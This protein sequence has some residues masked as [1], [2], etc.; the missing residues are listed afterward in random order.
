M[1]TVI[2]L[3]KAIKTLSTPKLL[4]NDQFCILTSASVTLPLISPGQDCEFFFQLFGLQ[5]RCIVSITNYS[6]AS[7]I[8]SYSYAS[9]AAHDNEIFQAKATNLFIFGSLD[10]ARIDRISCPAPDDTNSFRAFT[11]HVVTPG[12]EMWNRVDHHSTVR[13]VARVTSS[14]NKQKYENQNMCDNHLF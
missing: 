14:V 3:C 10:P 11:I 1:R 2:C 9:A 6:S 4:D 12:Y 13:H 7:G 8:L 5:L